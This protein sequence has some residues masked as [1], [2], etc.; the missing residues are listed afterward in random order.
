LAF[1]IPIVYKNTSLIPR[2]LPDLTVLETRLQE[3]KTENEWLLICVPSQR[4]IFRLGCSS[5]GA[6]G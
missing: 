4:N 5:W 6:A 1:Q 2:P 3:Y